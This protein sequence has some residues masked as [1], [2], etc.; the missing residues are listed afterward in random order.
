MFYSLFKKTFDFGISLLIL[1]LFW[2]LFALIALLIKLNSKGPAFLAQNRIGL[3]GREFTCFKFRT[4]HVGTKVAATHEVSADSVTGIGRFLRKTKL[5]ELPHVW[6]IFKNEM[7][8][9]GPRPCL[10]SQHELINLRTQANIL[11]DL[12]GITGWAQVQGIDMSNPQRLVDTE[13]EYLLKRSITLEI[14]ILFAT[15]IGQGNGDRTH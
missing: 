15:F 5:D 6:N 3:D 13:A 10:P 12:P 4:M 11:K 9:V 2:W 1:V 7:S 14:R 8:F